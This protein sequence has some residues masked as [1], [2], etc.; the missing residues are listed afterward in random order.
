MV[1]LI[2]GSHSLKPLPPHLERR[3]ISR[4]I[5]WDGRKTRHLKA[6][7]PGEVSA[8]VLLIDAVAH[9]VVQAVRRRAE[10]RGLP[11]IYARRSRTSIERT[12]KILLGETPPEH[13]RVGVGPSLRPLIPLLRRT[14]GSLVSLLGS[15]TLAAPRTFGLGIS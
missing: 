4:I 3:G 6:P 10:N 12:L 2:V 5:H 7:I 13:C 9:D 11:I 8:V 1:L 15:L 14:Y